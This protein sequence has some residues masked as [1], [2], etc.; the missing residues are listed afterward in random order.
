[1]QFDFEAINRY[2]LAIVGLFA[3]LLYFGLLY[4][5][6]VELSRAH[7]RR[8]S[9][10]RNIAMDAP[11]DYEI[12]RDLLNTRRSVISGLDPQKDMEYRAHTSKRAAVLL[13]LFTSVVAGAAVL[14]S[15]CSR[16]QAADAK[17]PQ[18]LNANLAASDPTVELC[19]LN[20][21]PSRLRR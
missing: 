17:V 12:R 6:L 13:V 2:V 15:G 4:A 11:A 7:Q 9:A 10:K 14:E 18:P 21:A 5:G 3:L 16:G 8:K 1:M 19:R 20:Y